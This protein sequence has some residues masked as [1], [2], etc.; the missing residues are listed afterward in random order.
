MAAILDFQSAQQHVCCQM[1]Q[2]NN[3]KLYSIGFDVKFVMW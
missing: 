1:C 2:W 3:L